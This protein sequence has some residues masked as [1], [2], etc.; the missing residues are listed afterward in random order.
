MCN[1]DWEDYVG[2]QETSLEEQ[3]ADEEHATVKYAEHPEQRS[4]MERMRSVGVPYKELLD[5]FMGDGEM[6]ATTLDGL[7]LLD[8]GY[9]QPEMPEDDDDEHVVWDGSFIWTPA[10]SGYAA[11]MLFVGH[12]APSGDG[13]PRAIVVTDEMLIKLYN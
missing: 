1:L 13:E 10:I 2:A 7:S 4:T 8:L 6:L 12:S 11:K 5:Q 9:A 3:L